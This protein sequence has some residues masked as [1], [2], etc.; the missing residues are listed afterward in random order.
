MTELCKLLFLLLLAAP[1]GSAFAQSLAVSPQMIV[2]A[3]GQSVALTARATTPSVRWS[4]RGPRV[5]GANWGSLT[6]SGA[7]ATYTA[8]P[9]PPP[10]LVVVQV[11][12]LG[13]YGEPIA[14]VD[15]PVQFA[16]GGFPILA[17]PPV[18]PPPATGV[19]P[20]PLPPL[21]APPPPAVG[22]PLPPQLAPQPAGGAAAVLAAIDAGRQFCRRGDVNRGMQVWQSGQAAWN[23]LGGKERRSIVRRLLK[24]QLGNISFTDDISKKVI[25]IARVTGD[26]NRIK[27][28]YSGNFTHVPRYETPFEMPLT[29]P[30]RIA[31]FPYRTALHFFCYEGEVMRV[32]HQ[33]R[34]GCRAVGKKI[35][36]EVVALP[37]PITQAAFDAFMARHGKGNLTTRLAVSWMFERIAAEPKAFDGSCDMSLAASHPA[38]YGSRFDKVTFLHDSVAEDRGRR[39]C[40]CP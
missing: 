9:V 32:R 8:P 15:V 12:A 16:G 28:V 13:P 19:L 38:N 4:M 21:L 1:T 11:Q 40:A 5:A 36:A 10:G 6:S 35:A 31:G 24:D 2:V 37:Q 20:L 22:V 25:N 14:A 23:G 27:V 30:P 39:H 7:F 29:I 26:G 3:P 17:P 33:I 34:K 18:A